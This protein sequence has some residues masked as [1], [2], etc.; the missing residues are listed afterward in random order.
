MQT[1]VLIHLLCSL[2]H[3]TELTFSSLVLICK[4]GSQP[5]KTNG[6]YCLRTNKSE[7]QNLSFLP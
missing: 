4:M 5:L 2:G 1:M 6:T 3:G 7:F